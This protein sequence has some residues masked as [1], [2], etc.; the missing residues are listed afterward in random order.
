M[1]IEVIFLSSLLALALRTGVG[2]W[3]EDNEIIGHLKLHYDVK[4]EP[5]N[6]EIATEYIN[7]RR[8]FLEKHGGFIKTS[9]VELNIR[10]NNLFQVISNGNAIMEVMK[11][12]LDNIYNLTSIG[13]SEDFVDLI[14]AELVELRTVDK[15]VE[16]RFS[17]YINKE[18]V[19]SDAVFHSR[20]KKGIA[21]RGTRYKI[22]KDY[23]IEK[24][25]RIFKKNN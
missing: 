21:A 9:P 11:D 2:G 15:E 17:A 16:S 13:R 25:K 4:F 7:N 12:I 5:L 24:G 23:K 1:G 14:S 18:S 6:W 8:N 22:S 3:I 20:S 19:D 10:G